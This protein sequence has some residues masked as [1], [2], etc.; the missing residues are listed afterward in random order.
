MIKGN[1]QQAKR[2][3][4]TT[5]G[6]SLPHA[7]SL[8]TV[9]YQ[10]ISGERESQRQYFSTSNRT[11]AS[12]DRLTTRTERQRI[13]G[14]GRYLF[15]SQV[16]LALFWFLVPTASIKSVAREHVTWTNYW[17]MGLISSLK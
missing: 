4:H 12:V 9:K 2:K 14:E 5:L 17:P 8:I 3:S 7:L 1:I 13:G 6:V 15:H 16:A 11:S 10:Y